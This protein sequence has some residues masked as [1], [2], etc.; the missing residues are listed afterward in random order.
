MSKAVK[1]HRTHYESGA[2]KYEEGKVY[3]ATE[4]TMRQAALGHAEV[5][6]QKQADTSA[7]KKTVKPDEQAAS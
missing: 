1:F 2:P 6:D 3:P 4:E 5:I 7:N